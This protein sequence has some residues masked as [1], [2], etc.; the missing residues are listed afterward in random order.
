MEE[1]EHF[2]LDGET[3]ARV[4]EVLSIDDC[5]ACILIIVSTY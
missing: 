3:A 4:E 5:A 1:A 2:R